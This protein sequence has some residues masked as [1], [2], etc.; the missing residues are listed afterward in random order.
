MGNL[1]GFEVTCDE[2]QTG[3]APSKGLRVTFAETWMCCSHLRPRPG[4][5][6]THAVAVG[7]EF[8][9]LAVPVCLGTSRVCV[10]R[11]KRSLELSDQGDVGTRPL[12]PCA[13]PVGCNGAAVFL[14]GFCI[15]RACDTFLV[16]KC[17]LDFILHRGSDYRLAFAENF[18]ALCRVQR[19]LL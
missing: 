3:T 6:G 4:E 9:G 7:A 16:R 19:L 13:A 15:L 17:H 11:A 5:T 8:P 18:S 1:G 14:V 12:P 10:V 2:V